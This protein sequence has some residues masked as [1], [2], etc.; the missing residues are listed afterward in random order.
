MEVQEVTVLIDPFGKV[1]LEVRGVKGEGCRAI[2]EGIEERLGGEVLERV[3]TPE[4]DEGQVEEVA[5]ME[6][7]RRGK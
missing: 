2:T 3:R 6:Y 7:V 1:R 4:A 5:D